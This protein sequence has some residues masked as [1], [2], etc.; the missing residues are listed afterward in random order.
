[1]GSGAKPTAADSCSRCCLC[2]IELEVFV[3]KVLEPLKVCRGRYE[4]FNELRTVGLS[5]DGGESD[6][7]K[8]EES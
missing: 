1:M 5:G 8:D 2:K 6:C 7:G 3:G 4:V